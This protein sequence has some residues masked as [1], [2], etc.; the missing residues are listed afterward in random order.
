MAVERGVPVT[1]AHLLRQLDRVAEV[2]R[3]GAWWTL[4]ALACETNARFG[5]IDSEAALSARLRDL[6]KHG[7]AVER[8][9]TRE[10]SNQ[11]LY[12]A[13]APVVAVGEQARLPW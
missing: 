10:G 3:P 8:K 4:I 2:M 12:R 5:V 1:T 11:W 7:W 9:R 13:T 6:R